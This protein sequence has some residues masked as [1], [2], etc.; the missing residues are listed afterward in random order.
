MT[1]QPQPNSQSGGAPSTASGAAKIAVFF[2]LDKT[3]IARNSAYAFNKY[4]FEH[5]YITPL[6][7]AKLGIGHLNYLKR[8]HDANQMEATRKRLSSF[9]VG[10]RPEDLRKVA[11][12]NLDTAIAPYVYAE[13]RDLISR[14]RNSGHDLYIVSAS[15]RELVEPIASILGVDNIIATKLEVKD[16]KFTGEVDFFCRGDNKSGEIQRIAD[17]HGYD[18]KQCFAYSDSAT[19][20][21]MLS[22]VGFPIVVNPDPDLRAIA[23]QRGWPIQDFIDPEPILHPLTTKAAFAAGITIGA[24]ALVAG[25]VAGAVA[26]SKGRHR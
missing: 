25:A 9:L 23:Q 8:G 18:L 26:F 15:A 17:R 5:G 22:T 24:G 6:T 16:G 10:Y 7:M 2:D 13:A 3:L 4:F 12:V 19:D 14:H 1:K 21:P 11:E 20:V